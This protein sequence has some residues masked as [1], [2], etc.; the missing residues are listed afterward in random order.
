[1]LWKGACFMLWAISIKH[2]INIL[3]ML[4]I[5]RV[6]GVL[7]SWEFTKLFIFFSLAFGHEF[8]HKSI[9][10]W[11][12]SFMK[13]IMMNLWNNF[14][15]WKGKYHPAT[16]SSR[17]T[18]QSSGGDWYLHHMSRYENVIPISRLPR[19]LAAVHTPSLPR[20]HDARR[21]DNSSLQIIA[22]ARHPD[23]TIPSH[24]LHPLDPLL[25][26]N[27]SQTKPTKTTT[28]LQN[29]GCAS[30]QP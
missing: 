29:L 25:P 10:A 16:S 6:F 22:Q 13:M 30:T 17:L 3:R 23:E 14:W 9:T 8:S 4:K 5:S 27:N 1:M 15:T 24:S 28:H 7:H 26:P 11:K 20:V 18:W 19:T 21:D 2:E 12:L